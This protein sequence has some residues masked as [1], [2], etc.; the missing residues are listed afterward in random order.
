[1]IRFLANL[2]LRRKL[3]LAM[4]PLALMVVVA[5]MYASIQSKRIDTHYTKLLGQDLRTVQDLARAKA[6][7]ALFGQLL[8]EETAELNLDK[9]RLIDDELDKTYADY[10]TLVAEAVQQSPNR[11]NQI[12]ADAALFDQAVADCSDQG[13]PFQPATPKG[14][15]YCHDGQRDGHGSR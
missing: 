11:A 5:G 2:K 10:R 6:Q 9:M 13:N 15:H 3:L 12:N 4:A 8:Y 7:V 1:M 14:T